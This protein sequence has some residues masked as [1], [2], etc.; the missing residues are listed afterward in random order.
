[1]NAGP[2]FPAPAGAGLVVVYV[3]NHMLVVDKPAGMLSVPDVGGETSALDVAKVWVKAAF[4]KPGDVFLGV[5][6][7]LDRPVSGLLIFGRTSKGAARLSAS[8][9]DGALSKTY[10]AVVAPWSAPDD[11]EVL[12]HL[13]KDERTNR[14]RWS[15]RASAGSKLAHSR[16]RVIARTQD[17]VLLA[18]EAVTGRPHQLRA[19]AASLGHPLLGDLK[20]GAPKALADGQIALH[21]VHLRVPHP[22]Q[23]RTLEFTRAPTRPVFQAHWT[24]HA[25]VSALE[26][27][28]ISSDLG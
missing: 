16:F 9:R 15:A 11:G 26:R 20:Y 18:L 5:V 21:A 8:L 17:R 1:M 6:H 7:R 19:A 3:D 12:H 27:S 13:V 23:P 22:T 24:P 14:V 28:W 4:D 10:L 25:Q 2:Q